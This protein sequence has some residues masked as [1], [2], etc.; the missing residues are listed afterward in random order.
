MSDGK[1][2]AWITVPAGVIALVVLLILLRKENPKP[3]IQPPI[4]AI[5]KKTESIPSKP[6]PANLTP[7]QQPV[8]ATIPVPQRPV[9]LATG[10]IVGAVWLTKNDGSSNLL[11]GRDIAILTRSI[12]STSIVPELRKQI[13]RWQNLIDDYS[14]MIRDLEDSNRKYEDVGG[15]SAKTIAED[16]K[17]ISEY[18]AKMKTIVSYCALPPRNIDLLDAY[19]ILKEASTD[20]LVTIPNLNELVVLRGRTNVD[21][22]Y[23][24]TGIPVGK[25]YVYSF[26]GTASVWVEWLVPIDVKDGEANV[27]LDNSNA[28]TLRNN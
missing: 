23:Q 11:R 18:N 1:V 7:A 25:Y 8:E 12:P 15:Y 9:A 19:K 27:D 24:I 21:G 17:T 22:K 20:G 28:A 10:S 5:T 3:V 13:P 6:R 14:K 26:F 4:G 16:R 2:I